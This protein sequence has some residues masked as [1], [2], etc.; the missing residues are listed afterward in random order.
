MPRPRLVRWDATC[1]AAVG[2]S[3]MAMI[4]SLKSSCSIRRGGG[5]IRLR[6]GH[7]ILVLRP[8]VGYCSLDRILGKDRAM[9]L[10]RGERQLL[11]D[12]RVADRHR[13]VE[14]LAL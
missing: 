14:C 2:V 8:V 12:L 11:R 13:L 7:C 10:H 6:V 3:V 9:D 4:S 5:V 1:F